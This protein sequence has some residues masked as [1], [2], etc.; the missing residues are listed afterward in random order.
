MVQHNG[1][2]SSSNQT[3][4]HSHHFAVEFLI[5]YLTSLPKLAALHVRSWF[6]VTGKIEPFE[7][8]GEKDIWQTF[9]WMICCWNV[10]RLQLKVFDKNVVVWQYMK[11][12]FSPLAQQPLVEQD[13]SLSWFHNHIHL[14]TPHS[15]GLLW[16]S[17]QPDAETSTWKHTTL[18]RDRHPCPRRDSNQQYQQASGR[19]PTP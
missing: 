10:C 1:H 19:I 7:R 3:A 15:V 11:S 2:Y 8:E 18:S 16:T 13:P 14:D 5:P 12:I 9:A 17:D 6:I 4:I